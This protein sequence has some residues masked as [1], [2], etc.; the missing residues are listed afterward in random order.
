MVI[1]EQ[2]TVK[3]YWQPFD[4]IENKKFSQEEFLDIFSKSVEKRLISDVPIASFLSGGLDSTS[5]VKKIS[6]LGHRVNTFSVVVDKSEINEESYIKEV[7]SK[8]NTNHSQIKVE[9][10]ISSKNVFEALDCLDEPYGDPSIVP[11]FLLSK[12]ISQDF[13]VAIS[14]DGGD[15][16]LGGYSRMK[17]HLVK[18]SKLKNL[19]S[20]LYKTYP[21]LFGTGTRLKSFS[22]DF[23]EA[24]KSYIEDE[25]LVSLL[26]E[27]QISSQSGI[28]FIEDKSLY[29]SVLINEYKYYLSEQMMFKVDR[30]SMANSLEVRSPLVDN[31]LVEYILNTS[32]NYISKESQKLPLVDYLKEDFDSSFL[33]RPKQGFVFDYHTW[34][35]E[36][37]NLVSDIID[38]SELNKYFH[39]NKIYMLDKVKTRINALRLWRIF[40][41][42]NYL[43]SI[44]SL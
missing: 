11:S 10:S 4:F 33:N 1:W 27:T 17:N 8:Y 32:H 7:V 18:R 37:F 35:F 42:A 12:L 9:S 38:N 29:K 25:K 15:E 31:K 34:V 28:N 24:H 41:L 44:K 40:V 39:A 3:K 14:G 23:L 26:F 13:K 20:K 2:S 6:E 36:N 21:P 43:N 30:A 16:L 5:I 19:Y 22:N